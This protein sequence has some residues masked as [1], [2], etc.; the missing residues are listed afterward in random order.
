MH[1][2]DN[3][4]WCCAGQLISCQLEI[5]RPQWKQEMKSLFP[6]TENNFLFLH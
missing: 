2:G 4:E 6:V 5:V 1:F 3:L